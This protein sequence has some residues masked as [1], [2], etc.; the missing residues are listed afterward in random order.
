MHEDHTAKELVMDLHSTP[1]LVH[2]SDDAA[3]RRSLCLEPARGYRVVAISG[4]V[5][6]TQAGRIEDFV[7]QPGEAL[8][9]DSSGAAIVSSFGPADVEV[10][11]P[12]AA[13]ATDRVPV[14]TAEAIDRAQREARRLQAQAVHH[15][16]GAAAAWVRAGIRRLASLITG[17]SATPR[18]A[19][20]H[21]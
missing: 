14:V 6:V 17:A 19:P 2:L 9:L 11:A 1:N 8:T 16:F 3:G 13:S 10:I 21:C 5:W 4:E 12:R 20:R 15:A 7:L 18:T